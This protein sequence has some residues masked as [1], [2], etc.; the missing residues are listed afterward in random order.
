LVGAA[1]TRKEKEEKTHSEGT[2]EKRARVLETRFQ[3]T[4][5][6]GEKGRQEEDKSKKKE[7]FHTPKRREPN[8]S[9]R[10][11]KSPKNRRSPKRQ[12]RKKKDVQERKTKR[13]KQKKSTLRPDAWSTV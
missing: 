7:P 2:R 9:T 4:T 3:H 11:G 8:K 13:V 5:Y 12:T 1:P 6:L 10:D